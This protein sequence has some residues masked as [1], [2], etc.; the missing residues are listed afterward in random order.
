MDTEPTDEE[1]LPKPEMPFCCDSGCDTCV[2]D[3][4]AEQM[5]QWRFDVA[6]IRAERAAA[7]AAQK[8]GAT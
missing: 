8:E 7:Q 1:L 3:D 5:R 6:K 4:Y 2:M